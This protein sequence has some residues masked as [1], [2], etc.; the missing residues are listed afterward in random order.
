MEQR[1]GASKERSGWIGIALGLA[2]SAY[3]IAGL[4]AMWFRSPRVPYAD[5]WRF[6]ENLLSRTFPWNIL[7]PDNGHHEILP[8]WINLADIYW[9]Q[10]EQ[11][12][13]I[14]VAIFC[15]AASFAIVAWSVGRTLRPGTQQLAVVLVFAL[16]VFWLGNE[17]IL[18][19]AREAIHAYMV[20]LFAFIA[21]TLTG[22]ES[23]EGEGRRLAVA[24]TFAM[25]AAF[26]FGSGIA[27]FPAMFYLLGLRRARTRSWLLVCAFLA[28]T[29]IAYTWGRSDAT[30]S[31]VRFEPIAQAQLFLHWLAA[32]FVYLFW[33]FLDGDIAARLPSAGLR[34]GAGW[35]AG[36]WTTLFGNIRD[37]R[38][39]QIV[40][41]LIGI[42]AFLLVSW[43]AFR[44]ADSSARAQRL[45][46]GIATFG[47]TVGGVVA[48]S[49]LDYFNEFPGQI[50]ATRYLVWSSLFW[51][52]LLAAALLQM[53][54]AR[55][56]AC[57]ALLVALIVAPSQLWMDQLSIS[58]RRAAEQVALGAAVGVID[59][60][61]PSGETIP[62]EMLAALPLLAKRGITMYAWPET[63]LLGSAP[64]RLQTHPVAVG[65]L[66]LT[67]IDNRFDA[68]GMLVLFDAE[69]EHRR[70]LIMD[71]NGVVQGIAQRLPKNEAPGYR[72]W[73]RGVS[74]R[75]SLQ[76]VA[77]P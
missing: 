25:L 49:R 52:G 9:V 45:A 42:G 40:V 8:N 2:T 33:P 7:A 22:H 46:L 29:L 76:F 41:G 72:G 15:V 70:I 51:S 53:R 65:N 63:R 64:D 67:E 5:Q 55:R 12:L 27:T 54:S 44:C 23:R 59:R 26:S 4:L 3:V 38:T 13:V 20:T 58:M 10:G 21:I 37:S 31:T 24:S 48:L 32:P 30:T 28:L 61:E 39:P 19:H 68:P 6:Y 11:G 75:D 34:E 17:R 43:R 35:V 36:T 60:A 62:E 69:P 18:T 1:S 66:Q 73:L 57:V 50:Q 16:G 14:G 56:A 77:L 74:E 71:A 47:L